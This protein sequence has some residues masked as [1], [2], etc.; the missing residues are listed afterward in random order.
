MA[1]ERSDLIILTKEN[2]EEYLKNDTEKSMQTAN[3]NKLI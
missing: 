3:L 1:A 2:F